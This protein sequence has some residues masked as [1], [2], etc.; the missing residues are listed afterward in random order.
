MLKEFVLIP[1]LLYTAL[2]IYLGMPITTS[3][4]RTIAFCAIFTIVFSFIWQYGLIQHVSK[5]L[6]KGKP[7]LIF[8]II[9]M[10]V[11][12]LIGYIGLSMM[13]SID[14]RQVNDEVIRA[15]AWGL[16][17]YLLGTSMFIGGACS[18]RTHTQHDA[19]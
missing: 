11:S 13:N 6:T 18:I 19:L 9:W 15:M 8:L 3:G 16:N 4:P 7:Q 12:L 5:A 14:Y 2:S 1:R 17:I 10:L